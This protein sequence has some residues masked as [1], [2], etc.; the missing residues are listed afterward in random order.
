MRP[1]D[2]AKIITDDIDINNGLILEG[3]NPKT[4]ELTLGKEEEIPASPDV[5]PERGL[6]QT[7]LQQYKKERVHDDWWKTSK[8]QPEYE[9]GQHKIYTLALFQGTDSIGFVMSC[10]EKMLKGYAIKYNS[11]E[12]GTADH[13]WKHAGEIREQPY[14]DEQFPGRNRASK[15]LLSGK[16]KLAV[17]TVGYGFEYEPHQK[18]EYELQQWQREQGEEI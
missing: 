9:Q 13:N 1:E 11:N 5:P 12:E 18:E 3:W 15:L 8:Q 2:I 6:S 7:E 14:P 17:Y 4:G 16:A 10:S